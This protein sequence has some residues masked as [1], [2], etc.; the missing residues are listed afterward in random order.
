MWTVVHDISR[1]QSIGFMDYLI[2]VWKFILYSL[3]LQ[4]MDR[5]ELTAKNYHTAGKPNGGG[6]H[7]LRVF[8]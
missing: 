7:S 2:C 1:K 4:H 5:V 3:T 8:S 6:L